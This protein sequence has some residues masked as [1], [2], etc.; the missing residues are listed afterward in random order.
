MPLN[1]SSST[2]DHCLKSSRIKLQMPL[3][4]SFTQADLV[5]PVIPKHMRLRCPLERLEES[6][7]STSIES[8]TET[9][10]LVVNNNLALQTYTVLK[11]R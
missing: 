3:E 9:P 5:A 8:G 1:S 4:R 6:L 10:T 2:V 11:I 7:L